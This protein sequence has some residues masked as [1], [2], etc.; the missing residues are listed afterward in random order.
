MLKT[1][2][3]ICQQNLS[4]QKESL[5]NIRSIKMIKTQRLKGQIHNDFNTQRED[6]CSYSEFNPRGGYSAISFSMLKRKSKHTLQHS[7]TAIGP[8]L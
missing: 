5:I 2:N 3:Q 4:N 1:Q 6:L 8:P 7:A